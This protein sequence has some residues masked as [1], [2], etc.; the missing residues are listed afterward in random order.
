[1]KRHG[2][3]ESDDAMKVARHVREG[4]VGKGP[5]YRYLAGGLLH[6]STAEGNAS[7]M[8]KGRRAMEMSAIVRWRP[9]TA[10]G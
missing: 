9:R 1:L 10:R 6:I 4:A 2:P 8:G 3:L 5:R 7:D